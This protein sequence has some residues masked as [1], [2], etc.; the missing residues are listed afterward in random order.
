MTESNRR[1][2]YLTKEKLNDWAN[3]LADMVEA[4]KMPSKGLVQQYTKALNEFKPRKKYVR[5]KIKGIIN[6]N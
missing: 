2:S 3:M 6:E 5:Y 4:G 1:G